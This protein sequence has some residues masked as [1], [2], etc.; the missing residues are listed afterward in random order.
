MHPFDEMKAFID[1]ARAHGV[2][3]FVLLSAIREDESTE[4]TG[5]V[6]KYLKEMEGTGIGWTVLRPTWFMGE[7]SLPVISGDVCM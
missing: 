5:R 7:L 1:I 6:H 3:R 2:Q 4:G